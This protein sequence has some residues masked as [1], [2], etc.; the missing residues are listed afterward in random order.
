[1]S[2]FKSVTT[3][4][5]V[6]WA[7]VMPGQEEMGYLGAYEAFD[8]AFTIDQELS[9]EEFAKL[10]EAGSQ[11]RPVQKHLMDGR[12]VLKFVRKNRVTNGKGELVEAASGAPELVD[13]DGNPW[14]G[15][16][17]GNGS[18]CVLT[19]LLSFFKAPDGTTGCRTTLTK[20]Q[21]LEHI[22]FESEAT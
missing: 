9:K 18:V 3:V 13:A 1:M 4:G 7:K 11:K 14:Y 12:I 5:P 21:V 10:K 2:K 17:I 15:E 19:N 8:G 22:A 20:V 6:F 16:F